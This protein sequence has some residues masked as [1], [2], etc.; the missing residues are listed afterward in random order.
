MSHSDNHYARRHRATKVRA[1]L[2]ALHV[3]LRPLTQ[4]F[5]RAE[6]AKLADECSKWSVKEW[7]LLAREA[8]C[9]PPTFRQG[10]SETVDLVIADL[11][12][13]AAGRASTEP[14]P[15]PFEDPREDV[16]TELQILEELAQ[17][18]ADRDAAADAEI[19][20]RDRWAWE[21][22]Q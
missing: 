14:T 20:E 21:H 5:S 3:R 11:I 13:R 17:L 7:R 6:Y 19:E 8:G 15:P 9:R 12:D 16:E 22:P 10:K 2:W 18:A 4:E 1:L